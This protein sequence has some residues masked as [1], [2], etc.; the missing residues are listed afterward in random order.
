MTSHVLR[1]FGG[2]APVETVLGESWDFGIRIGR[3][4]VFR[5]CMSWVSARRSRRSESL[6]PISGSGLV[7]NDSQQGPIEED[8]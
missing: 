3:S 4:T 1:F 2:V 5:R 7:L 8:G 6:A